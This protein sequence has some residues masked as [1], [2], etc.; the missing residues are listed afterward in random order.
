MNAIYFIDSNTGW[1]VGAD[2]IILKTTNGGDN[3]IPQRSGTINY[4]ESVFFIDSNTGWAVGNDGT[5]LK[6]NNGGVSFIKNNEFIPTGFY[7]YQNFPN[8]FNPSTKI[9]YSIPQSSQVQIKIFDIL[10]NEMETLV[11]EEKPSGTYE[12]TWNASSLPSGV[13]FY[14]IQAGDFVETKKMVLMK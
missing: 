1:V 8:P 2:G 10:G 3:W 11:S 12:L 7:L 13:Y 5:I 14:R 4:F 6:T 9:K